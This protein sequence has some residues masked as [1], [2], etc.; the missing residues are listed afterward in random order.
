MKATKKSNWKMYFI[1][2]SLSFVEE[3]LQV[4]A[5]QLKLTLVTFRWSGKLKSKKQEKHYFAMIIFI[6][7]FEG[8][9]KGYLVAI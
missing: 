8:K 5:L 2:F 1:K 3:V 4:L 7:C 9:M 6:S